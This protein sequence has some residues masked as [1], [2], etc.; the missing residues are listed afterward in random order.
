MTTQWILAVTDEEGFVK[1]LE[2]IVE[3]L[4]VKKKADKDFDHVEVHCVRPN[5]TAWK[6]AAA[7]K[8]EDAFLVFCEKSFVNT[9]LFELR[10]TT[11]PL[12]GIIDAQYPVADIDDLYSEGYA[13]TRGIVSRTIGDP[14][15]V[16]ALARL[17]KDELRRKNRQLGKPTFKKIGW[18][19]QL[20]KEP[21]KRRLVSLFVDPVM[22]DFMQ[23]L[24]ITAQTAEQ[25]CMTDWLL[26]DTNELRELFG[27]LVDKDKIRAAEL[28]A[29]NLLRRDDVIKRLGTTERPKPRPILLEGET[30]VGKTVISEWIH[31]Y[32]AQ[33]AGTSLQRISTV[34][35]GAQIVEA[36]LFGTTQG[37]WT[38]AVSRPG[39]LLLNRGGV[40]LLDE[41]GDLPLETQAKLLV[42]LDDFEFVPDGWPYEW[43]IYCPLYVIAATNR[44]LRK[45]VANGT[46][47]SDLYHRFPFKLR[48]PALRERRGDLRAL[49][50]LILQDPTI[51]PSRV[52]NRISL[53]AIARLEG[54]EFPGNFRELETVL[55]EAVFRARQL[56]RSDLLEEDLK[57]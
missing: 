45:A 25:P 17:I 51:N 7:E 55:G 38:G 19:L 10:K 54:Y 31:R 40:V 47:R 57:L 15:D 48:V 37:A 5:K 41:I 50:D 12:V 53:G 4:K 28:E 11:T 23:R 24:A 42:F 9:L 2:G 26:T 21:E 36:E 1:V 18:R 13:Y 44:D 3:R 29:R 33:D 43:R 52:V 35:I 16:G 8:L 27:K 14:E 6:T 46:F 34:N 20:G 56:G 39:R 49:V 30:G 22:R 32:L